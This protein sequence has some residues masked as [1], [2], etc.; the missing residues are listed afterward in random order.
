MNAALTPS[1]MKGEPAAHVAPAAQVQ[2]GDIHAEFPLFRGKLEDDALFR[3]CQRSPC[4]HNSL[5]P[6]L[7]KQKVR[8][9]LAFSM[10]IVEPGVLRAHIPIILTEIA[11]QSQ[12]KAGLVMEVHI[13]VAVRVRRGDRIDR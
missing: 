11:A 5:G 8:R 9:K 2:I 3:G 13:D 10:R 1:R 4:R 12:S 6:C 7:K